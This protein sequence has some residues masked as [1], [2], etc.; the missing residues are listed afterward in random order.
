MDNVVVAEHAR[1][2]HAEFGYARRKDEVE[3]RYGIFVLRSSEL[4]AHNGLGRPADKAAKRRI[5][6]PN[7][8]RLPFCAEHGQRRA[9]E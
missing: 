5:D 4:A 9:V 8:V 1:Q 7:D 6:I 2:V 3:Q